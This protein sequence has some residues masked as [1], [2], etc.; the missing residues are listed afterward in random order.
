MI[1]HPTF[2]LHPLSCW[3]A[4]KANLLI[5]KAQGCYPYQSERF[6]TQVLCEPQPHRLSDPV[7]S[8]TFYELEKEMT[9]R[10]EAGSQKALCLHQ[11]ARKLLGCSFGVTQICTAW[12]PCYSCFWLQMHPE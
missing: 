10:A 3:G 1:P 2:R 8:K 9:R 7:S 6:Q 11:L 12:E 5:G 4:G